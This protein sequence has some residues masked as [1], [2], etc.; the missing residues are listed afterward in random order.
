M[1]A[2]T[3]MPIH[4]EMGHPSGEGG[5]VGQALGQREQAWRWNLDAWSRLPGRGSGEEEASG[6]W[7]CKPFQA[8]PALQKGEKE[9]M[10]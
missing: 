10:H 1:K 6:M 7:G 4:S 3:C 9:T 2:Y 8:G 5:K